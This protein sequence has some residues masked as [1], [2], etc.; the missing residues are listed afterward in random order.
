M[1]D[2][3]TVMETGKILGGSLHRPTGPFP[4]GIGMVQTPVGKSKRNVEYPIRPI[5]DLRSTDDGIHHFPGRI[6]ILVTGNDQTSVRPT[7]R[8]ENV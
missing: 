7:D 8:S 3:D 5:P 4:F 2:K 1:A 6:F